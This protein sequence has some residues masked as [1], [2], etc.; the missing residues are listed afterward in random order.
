MQNE[1]HITA[2][3]DFFISCVRE[4]KE[5]IF[6]LIE[7]RGYEDIIL[8]FSNTY[9]CFPDAILPIIAKIN[10]YQDEGISFSIITPRR[11][12]LQR[13]FISSNWCHLIDPDHYNEHN[14]PRHGQLPARRFK[15]A[16][17]QNVVVNEVMD[18]VL[19]V[20]SF[21]E[22][23]DIKA[24]EWAVNEITDN[25]I[26]HSLS[27]HGGIIQLVTKTKSQE[28]EFNVSDCG[29]GI[30]ESLRGGLGTNWTDIQSIEESI[31]E[32]VTRGTGQGNG[33]FGSFQIATESKGAFSIN[34]GLAAMSLSRSG[35]VRPV[36]HDLDWRGTSIDCCISLHRPLI[37]E[38]ALK[39]HGMAHIPLDLIDIKYEN[40]EGDVVFSI[41]HEAKSIGSRQS[42]LEVRKK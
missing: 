36:E 24:L 32:G 20:A 16:E 1:N 6:N 8:D 33:L 2:Q 22:R 9:G 26:T 37:L 35:K 25:V 42:G 27:D 13:T 38:K 18:H 30:P 17:S 12:G 10:K 21:L 28:I 11:A 15:D 41:Y 3:E 23:N 14:S 40:M 29:I 4:T 7:F 19:R 34:S 31:K 39:F 5:N